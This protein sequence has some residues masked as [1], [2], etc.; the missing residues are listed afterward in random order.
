MDLLLTLHYGVFASASAPYMLQDANSCN[1]LLYMHYRLGLPSR[2]ERR[3]P[4]T[5]NFAL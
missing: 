2:D 5:S 1:P 3:L 4:F